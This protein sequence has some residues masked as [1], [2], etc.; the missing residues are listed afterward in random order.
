MIRRLHRRRTARAACRSARSALCPPR[1]LPPG[2]REGRDH[3]RTR[4]S[5]RKAKLP[6]REF[7][8]R[9][10]SANHRTERTRGPPCGTC[11]RLA[12]D[13]TLPR[14]VRARA[15]I[16]LAWLL[17]PIDLIPEFIPVIG[18]ADDIIVVTILLR[19]LIRH[20]GPEAV[21]R[22]WP[23]TPQ[24][25]AVLARLCKLPIPASR[26]AAPLN[27]ARDQSGNSPPQPRPPTAAR[28]PRTANPSTWIGS[29]RTPRYLGSRQR[30]LQNY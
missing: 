25:L 20:A 17:S 6:T 18:P 14:A 3:P 19:S 12:A 4:A 2:S 7:T 27:P 8:S 11:R 28:R 24:G 30:N 26:P 5:D 21:Q 15:W 23:G 9:P 1:C 29:S 13:R 16:A 22:H 10:T